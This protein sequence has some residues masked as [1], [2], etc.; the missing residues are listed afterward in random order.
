MTLLPFEDDPRK[1]VYARSGWEIPQLDFSELIEQSRWQSEFYV[2][3]R[4]DS[5]LRNLERKK[6]R[7]SESDRYLPTCTIALV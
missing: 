4:T 2:R 6:R 3:N 1:Q 5:L 7:S